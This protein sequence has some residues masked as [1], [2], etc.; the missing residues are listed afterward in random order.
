MMPFDNT[1]KELLYTPPANTLPIAKVQTEFIVNYYNNKRTIL[2]PPEASSLNNLMCGIQ[3][4][5]KKVSVFRKVLVP[6]LQSGAD[7]FKTRI[8]TTWT[9]Y[10]WVLF[11][12]D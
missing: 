12:G 1:V 9:C 4:D 7:G 3:D 6:L 11:Q 5:V 10:L 2:S 8:L